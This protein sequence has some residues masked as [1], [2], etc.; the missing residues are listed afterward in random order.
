MTP[1]FG[2]HRRPAPHISK[3]PKDEATEIWHF[4][5]ESFMLDD[6]QNPTW[7]AGTQLARRC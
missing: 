2:F 3:T 7:L 6:S 4:N 5:L 1:W